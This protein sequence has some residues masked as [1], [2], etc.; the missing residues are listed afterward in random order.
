VSVAASAAVL[1]PVATR[2]D[3]IAMGAAGYRFGD[4]W[5]LGLAVMAIFF[6]VAVLVVPVFWPF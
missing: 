1:T 6:V 4:D 2:V 5:K 3:L